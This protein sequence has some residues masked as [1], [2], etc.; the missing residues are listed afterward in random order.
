MPVLNM[1]RVTIT[2]REYFELL[3]IKAE[4]ER[5]VKDCKT[6]TR[7]QVIENARL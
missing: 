4:V 6:Y 1:R 7:K 2:E 3:R 5:K